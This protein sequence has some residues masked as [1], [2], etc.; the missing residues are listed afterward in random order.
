MIQNSISYR[1]LKQLRW[2][3]WE[4]IWCSGELDHGDLVCEASVEGWL[5]EARE[6]VSPEDLERA[7]LAVEDTRQLLRD[8]A[9][10][11]AQER[12]ALL[13]WIAAIPKEDVRAS[14][15][16]HYVKGYRYAVIAEQYFGGSIS[17][18]AVRQMCGRCLRGEHTRPRGR[19][20]NPGAK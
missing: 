17:P 3:D 1:R 19:P 7:M 6:H 9:A 8:R 13:A 14:V 16:L 10:Y 11:A 15:Y 20:K 5:H 2:Y 18:D 12:E 4:I